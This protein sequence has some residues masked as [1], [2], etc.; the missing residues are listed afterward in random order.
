VLDVSSYNIG[1]KYL[2]EWVLRKDSDLEVPVK[3]LDAGIADLQPP[4]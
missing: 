3:Y 2:A 4:Q 1:L